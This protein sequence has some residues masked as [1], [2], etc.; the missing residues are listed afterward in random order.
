MSSCN[1][2]HRATGNC[3]RFMLYNR[4]I[5]TSKLL[6][7]CKSEVYKNSKVWMVLHIT[8]RT[9]HRNSHHLF[10]IIFFVVIIIILVHRGILRF[11]FFGDLRKQAR[12]VNEKLFLRSL[13]HNF[14]LK[15]IM[16]VQN[17]QALYTH[18]FLRLI[19]LFLS[20]IIIDWI[21]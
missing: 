10:V 16:T 2:C 6:I 7:V 1:S 21:C 17:Y 18:R 3:L 14:Y 15:I 9:R 8:H 13:G 12:D 11:T 4:K 5:T 20:C 19:C